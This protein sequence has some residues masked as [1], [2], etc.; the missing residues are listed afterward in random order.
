MI[1]H[2]KEHRCFRSRVSFA[3]P[4]QNVQ[5]KIGGLRANFFFFFI[6]R[7]GAQAVKRKLGGAHS[8]GEGSVR[9]VLEWPGEKEP[10]ECKQGK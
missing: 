8:G 5:E 4:W 2:R 6:L 1:A 10:S 7:K 3:I 9:W